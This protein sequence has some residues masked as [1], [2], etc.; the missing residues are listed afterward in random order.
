METVFIKKV[1]SLANTQGGAVA[2]QT[3][4]LICADL[5]TAGQRLDRY[6]FAQI[7]QYSRA[8]FQLLIE[9]G[10]VS[11]NG[12]TMSKSNYTVKLNDH[13]TVSLK[14]RECNLTPTPVNFEIIDEQPDYLII[15][16]PAGLLVHQATGAAEEVSLVNG[17]LHRFV[18]LGKGN[19][20]FRPGIVHRLDRNT[21]GILLV[22]RNDVSLIEL[23]AMFKQRQM[24]KTYLAIVQG[25]PPKEGV[26]DYPVGRHPTERHKMSVVGI[27][28]RPALTTY[29][30]L[31][32]YDQSA[33]VAARIMTGRTHQIRVHFAAIGHGLLG[34]T[35]Y[36]H[37]SPHI[38]RQALHAWKLAFTY[39]D[40]A[41]TYLCPLPED[42]K[43]L[44]ASVKSRKSH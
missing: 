6:L 7:P 2:E 37:T 17:L 10:L 16:K 28:T 42:M 21:S 3:I 30:T 13:I 19:E 8:Y 9:K 32:Y 1:T 35:T 25:H 4:S 24:H 12:Q 44:I 15:N 39:K 41:H 36:G 5:D 38:N 23:S 20:D 43:N 33:L 26:I 11:V 40:R 18:T 34:D 14:T 27:E 31:A 22:A 29:Q